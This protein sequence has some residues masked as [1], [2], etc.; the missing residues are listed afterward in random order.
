M[1]RFEQAS[2]DIARSFKT[3]LSTRWVRQTGRYGIANAILDAMEKAKSQE[4][5]DNLAYQFKRDILLPY[6]REVVLPMGDNEQRSEFLQRNTLMQMRPR[7]PMGSYEEL[8]RNPAFAQSRYK[9]LPYGSKDSVPSLGRIAGD[10]AELD[11][12]ARE[13]G[14]TPEDLQAHIQEQYGIRAREQFGKDMLA[15][16][17][18]GQRYRDSLVKDYEES[19]QGTVL[20]TIAPEYSGLKLAE[21][22]TGKTPGNWDVAKAIAKDALV[23]IGSLYTPFAAGKFVRNPA[24]QAFLGGALD[25]GIEAGRQAASDFYGFDPSNIAATGAVSATLPSIIGGV[26][27]MVGKVPGM[28]RITRPIMRKL[29]GLMQDPSDAERLSRADMAES[30]RR[31]T[32]AAYEGGDRVAREGAD[33]ILDKLQPFMEES[34]VRAYDNTP[35]TRDEVR[36]IVMDPQRAGEYFTPPTVDEFSDMIRRRAETGAEEIWDV[37]GVQK[38]GSDVAEDWLERAKKQWPETWKKVS[39]PEPPPTRLD[40][41]VG[42]LV[43]IGSREETMRQ[44]GKGRKLE[45]NSVSGALQ[46]VMEYDPDMIRMWKAGF[47]PHDEAGKKLYDEW[48]SKFGE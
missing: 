23:D 17:V 19:M 2:E 25:A 34:P 29:R 48:K 42:A 6:Y 46:Q 31:A 9:Y 41:V 8:Q 44:R 45:D 27:G 7:K 38:Y 28:G 32:E 10:P 3:E 13:L 12:A 20:G 37:G 40:R 14:V 18:E 24:A 36:D 22:R 30:A 43:D 33:D 15:A 16:A 1:N 35:L 11:L 4:Q 5:F 39:T 26:T 21:M 47:V